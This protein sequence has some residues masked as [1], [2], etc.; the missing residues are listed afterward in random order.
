MRGHIAG[1]LGKT[2]SK[3]EIVMLGIIHIT[4]LW[5]TALFTLKNDE[6]DS[7]AML[8]PID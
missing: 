2:E 5:N 7:S 3:F 8:V 4:I 6:A 1:N